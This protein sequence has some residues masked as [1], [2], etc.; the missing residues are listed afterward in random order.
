MK[1]HFG[2]SIK[3]GF[4]SQHVLSKPWVEYYRC[5]DYGI[6]YLYVC[7]LGLYANTHWWRHEI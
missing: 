5:K 1:K 7:V 2:F 6:G 4:E 3:V